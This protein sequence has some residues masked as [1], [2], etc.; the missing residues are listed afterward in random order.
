MF[1]H[2]PVSITSPTVDLDEDTQ[3]QISLP[4]YFLD[5]YP[6]VPETILDKLDLNLFRK[7]IFDFDT[8][9]A[10]VWKYINREKIPI[11]NVGI[12]IGGPTTTNTKSVVTLFLLL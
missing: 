11:K 8:A 7:S 9:N 4:G 3:I 12:S 2:L 10:E 6:S 1:S 5:L